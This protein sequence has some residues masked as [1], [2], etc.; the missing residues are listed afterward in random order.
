MRWI[1]LWYK[2]R[3]SPA[4]GPVDFISHGSRLNTCHRCNK[5][6]TQASRASLDTLLGSCDYCGRPYSEI[7]AAD[8]RNVQR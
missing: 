8:A 4:Q 1:E 6:T 5:P 7:L 2:P 3:S